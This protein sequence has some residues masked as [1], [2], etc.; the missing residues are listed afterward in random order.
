[1]LVVHLLLYIPI[2]FIIMRNMLLVACKIPENTPFPFHF[3]ITLVILS[4][5][6]LIVCL[7]N[8]GGVGNGTAFSYILGLTGR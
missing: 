5:A 6:I 4:A 3:I 1:M 8:Y 2:D 7:L